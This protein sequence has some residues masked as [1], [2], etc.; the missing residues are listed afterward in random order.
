MKTKLAL[1]VALAAS[2]VTAPSAAAATTVSPTDPNVKYSGRWNTSAPNAY[3]SEWAGAYLTVGFT[4]TTVRLRQRN[5]IDFFAAIDGGPFTSY[6]NR[7][8][9]VDLTP[10]PLAA[11][12]HTL[13]ISYRPIA[14]SYK[15][16]AV[17]QGITLDSGARTF[18]PAVPKKTV[19]FVG[20]S[21]TVGQLSSRQALTAYGWLVGEKLGAGHTRIAVGGACLSPSTDGCLAMRD[22]FLRTGL[23]A[24]A[25]PW[26]FSRYRADAVVVNLGTNDVGHG[27]TG[28]QF[29][30]AYV[31]LLRRARE[32]YPTAALFAMG[33]FRKRYL[34]ETQAAVRTLND[35]GDANVAFVDTTGWIVEATD[36]VDNV[37]PN[38][39]GHRKIAER[40]APIISA[41]L[42]G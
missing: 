5:A 16:D 8:G 41:R 37:H 29:Q 18:A 3:V 10:T 36:T 24:S 39:A 42:G 28:A 4:G 38:D 14:G 11:G 26:D 7:S 12:N 17:F 6:V 13:R 9:T 19:E 23:A 31:T 34:A 27:V 20:D 33:T 1:L 22:G 30:N 40:L 32:K 2:L 15:G 35:G 25:P 21:I